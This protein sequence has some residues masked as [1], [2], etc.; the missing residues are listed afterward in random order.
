[1]A[2]GRSDG[3]PDAAAEQRA[4]GPDE[5]DIQPPLTGSLPHSSAAARGHR[6][7]GGRDQGRMAAE[8]S[9]R[10]VIGGDGRRYHHAFEPEPVKMVRTDKKIQEWS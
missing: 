2:T 3:R 5:C 10:V 7:R 8:R 6:R 9:L 1:M 4:A